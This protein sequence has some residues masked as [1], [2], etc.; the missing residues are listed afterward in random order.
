MNTDIIMMVAILA[1]GIGLVPQIIDGFRTK[2]CGV[3]L[4]TSVITTV[5]LW[6]LVWCFCQMNLW[7]SAFGC[8][9]QG[10]M[11][12]I[13]VGQWFV[14]RTG[15]TG[16]GTCKHR[17]NIWWRRAFVCSITGVEHAK[18]FACGRF[19]EKGNGGR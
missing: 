4:W 7:F 11:W 5:A 2:K 17:M 15:M 3:V 8:S 16:C 13:M 19:A 12:G 10:T 6:V 9:T 18:G 1:L 14:Y